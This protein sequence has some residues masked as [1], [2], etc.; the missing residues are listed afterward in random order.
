MHSR[1]SGYAAA[2]RFHAAVVQGG[3]SA[4]ALVRHPKCF[5][6]QRD[7][8][9][10]DPIFRTCRGQHGRNVNGTRR[11]IGHLSQ[12]ACVPLRGSV[13]RTRRLELQV[14]P[15]V[16]LQRSSPTIRA[17]LSRPAGVQRQEKKGPRFAS[18]TS[19]LQQPRNRRFSRARGDVAGQRAPRPRPARQSAAGR[20]RQPATTSHP[21]RRMQT[22]GRWS[23]DPRR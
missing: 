12:T 8:T 5:R 19:L 17:E 13:H 6:L 14:H 2:E 10:Q 1:S 4:K 16:A 7:A 20:H 9:S 11:P 21:E 22:C 3:G 23:G 18:H 15:I